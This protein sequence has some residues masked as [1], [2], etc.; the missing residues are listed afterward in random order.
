ML[1]GVVLAGGESR[2]FGSDKALAMLSDAN[3][4]GHALAALAPH[5]RSLGI[6]GRSHGPAP[7]IADWPRPALG[8]LGGICGALRYA[9]REGADAILCVPC[10]MPHLPFGLIA[11][12]ADRPGA[13]YLTQAPVVGRWPVTLAEPLERW[14]GE[15]DDRS[16]IGW[17]R[18]IGAAPVS[19]RDTLANI[20]RPGDLQRV[21]PHP[22]DQK[23]EPS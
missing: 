13:A 9:K 14:L 2:R 22:T 7:T 21:A 19:W 12:I 6:A 20:N 18:S 3:L 1:I 8:P 17:A 4:L 23:R 15:T 11:D 16:I 5:V 10:D